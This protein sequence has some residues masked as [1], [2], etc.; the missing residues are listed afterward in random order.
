MLITLQIKYFLMFYGGGIPTTVKKCK[1]KKSKE[2]QLLNQI[3]DL[4][5]VLIFY[6]KKLIFV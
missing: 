3:L 6:R 2:K 1:K 4:I 5:R